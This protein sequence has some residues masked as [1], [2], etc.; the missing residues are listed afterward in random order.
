[1]TKHNFTQK[2]VF[3]SAWSKVKAN[4]WFLFTV[5]FGAAAVTAA[6]S[7]TGPVEWIAA[8]AIGIAITSVAL[9][10]ARGDTPSYHDVIK[11]FKNHKVP[12]NYTLA[13][14]L[15]LLVVLI[16]FA[17]VVALLGTLSSV[18]ANGYQSAMGGIII[19][20]SLALLVSFYFA[21]RLQFY[22]LLIVEDENLLPFAALK[23]SMH[24]TKGSFWKLFWFLLVIVI[25][26][27]I[28][29]IPA[30]LG[31]IVTIPVSVIAYTIVYRKFAEHA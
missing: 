23:K 25:M 16:G 14:I 10:I 27:I 22:K 26:N 18:M 30:G 7:R 31:L 5:F 8:V 20:S 29:A 6:L 19:V 28:G 4:A 13:T 2:E 24:M 15:Y 12:M 3:T 1:M 21:M 9:V 17:G 11:H